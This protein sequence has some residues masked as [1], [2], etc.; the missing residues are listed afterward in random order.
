MRRDQYLGLAA[1][2]IAF[3][4][5][6]NPAQAQSKSVKSSDQLARTQAEVASSTQKYQESLAAVLALDEE[7]VKEATEL[8]ATRRQLFD[9]GVVSKR[10]LEQS[11]TALAAAQAKVDQTREQMVES[12]NLKAEAEAAEELAK[13]LPAQ[14][15][16]QPKPSGIYSDTGVMIRHTG[17][18]RWSLGG[19]DE[20]QAFYAAKFGRSLPTSAVGQSATHNK[21]RFDHR[22][23][24]DVA[25]HPDSA[26]G[27]ALMD[28]LR[29]EGIPFIAFRS[30]VRGSATGA[31]IHI[32]LPSHRITATV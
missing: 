20:I 2:I 24:V 29:S 9:E 21:L 30:A 8:L 18:S 32:G 1:T 15:Q 4:M 13:T 7:R 25:V 12:D 6:L 28:Y 17:S 22:N 16:I 14:I 26:E 23:A 27:K 3:L 10:E 5:S 19:L 11:E 31:H